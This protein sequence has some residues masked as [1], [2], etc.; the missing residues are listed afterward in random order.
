ME[1]GVEWEITVDG[2]RCGSGR[3]RANVNREGCWVEGSRVEAV[4]IEK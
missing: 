3:G 4:D 2:S 1:R